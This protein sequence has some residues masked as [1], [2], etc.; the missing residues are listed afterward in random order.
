MEMHVPIILVSSDAYLSYALVMCW[1]VMQCASEGNSYEFYVMHND[2]PLSRQAWFQGAMSKWTQCRVNFL[3]VAVVDSTR[4]ASVWNDR[5]PCML[6]HAVY[7]LIDVDKAIAIDID[8]IV[9]KDLALLYAQD[10]DG[11]LLGAVYDLDFIGQWR[12]GNRR[13]HAEY[14]SLIPPF[15]PLSC[16]QAGIL[17]LDMCRLRESFQDDF[18]IKIAYERKYFYDD[19]D[20]WNYY[21]AGRIYP[22]DPRWNVVHDNRRCRIR[23]VLHFAPPSLLRQYLDARREPFIIHYA[24]DQ[25]PW[26]DRKCDFSDVFWSVADRTPVASDLRGGLKQER[27]MRSSMFYGILR[28]LYHE[29]R[30]CM[31]IWRLK[32]LAANREN[33]NEG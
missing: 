16:M 18:L 13:Y 8:V 33:D 15:E 19:Q 1:S 2:I 32:L 29:L 31:D 24:G 7:A 12:L 28:F 14:E 6:F 27:T 11:Q 10:L 30:R 9:R 17:L 20:I 23:Y 21:C 26:T 22:L 5:R 3:D 4:D 25:K